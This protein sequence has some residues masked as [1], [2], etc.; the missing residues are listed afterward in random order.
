MSHSP[1][2]F[3]PLTYISRGYGYSEKGSVL[4]IFEPLS[5]SPQ[6]LIMGSIHGDESLSTIL[7][8]DCLRS[9]QDHEL[10]SSIILAA[11]PDGVLAG[12]RCNSRGVDLNRN[13]PTDN[14]SPDPVYYRNRPGTPQNIALSP[15][16]VAASES[17]TKALIK[18]IQDIKPKLIVSIH[19]FLGCIDD[20][21]A[22]PIAKDIVLRSGLE[23]VPDV[24]Y[25][26]PGSF[27]SWCKEQ[28]IPIIT[29][30]LPSLDI[31]E[32]KRIHIP[33][34]KDLITGH[35]HKMLL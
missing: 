26:T 33:I 28:A 20:P 15:G 4:E 25:A 12:T 27:G 7:L 34:L 18:L 5:D 1:S 35:Y 14:W 10:K 22:S 19:G 16:D 3:G 17:E 11:N 9:I 32:M 2:E 8:S 6:I 13:Y 30:E 31:T 21:D 24:G 29:Y 23:L